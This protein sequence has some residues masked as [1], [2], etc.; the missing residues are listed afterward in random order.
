MFQ[1]KNLDINVEASTLYDKLLFYYVI[2]GSVLGI[3]ESY[4][5]QVDEKIAHI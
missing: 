2:L 1:S 3:E 5:L 4:S